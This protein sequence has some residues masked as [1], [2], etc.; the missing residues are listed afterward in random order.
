[1]FIIFDAE[2]PSDSPFIERVWRCHSEREGNFLAV[3]SS[4]W[5]MVVTRL[6]GTTTV[7]FH[8]P[9]TRS[10][11]VF[12][13][14]N[15][16]WFA[17]RF[18]A[19]AFMPSLPAGRMLNGQDVV[20]PQLSKR[21]F[22]LEGSKW[23]LPDY[24]NAE[25]FVARLVRAGILKRDPAVEAALPGDT[26]A[27]S[28]RSAQ[29]HFLQATGITHTT[30]RKIERARYATNLLRRGVPIHDTMHEAGYFD[31]AHLTRSLK[32]LVGLTPARIALGQDQLSFLYN[33][34]PQPET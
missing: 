15:G 27:L 5:E 9:E 21:T 16:E 12:C 10:R 33:T 26:L 30:L 19:G 29:R 25:V 23:E 34:T 13:P 1:M 7:T 6:N 4:H 18:K 8:G 24:D 31:Q 11:E 14:A 22:H 3:A 2:R 28:R 17:I 32:A 20:L